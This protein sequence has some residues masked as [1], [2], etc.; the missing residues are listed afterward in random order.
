MSLN[1]IAFGAGRINRRTFW[2]WHTSLLGLG[3]ALSLAINLMFG[4]AVSALAPRILFVI[5]WVGLDWLWMAQTARRLHDFGKSAAWA[6]VPQMLWLGL[7]GAS[8]ALPLLA[9]PEPPAL[10]RPA[11]GGGAL[12]T[13]LGLAGLIWVGLSRGDHGA[14]KFGPPTWITHPDPPGM[15]PGEA[16]PK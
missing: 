8:L 12:A 13:T 14:N 6:A 3:L 10:A 11:L 4:W 1:T 15:H 5:V 7:V 9:L 16:P 2:L